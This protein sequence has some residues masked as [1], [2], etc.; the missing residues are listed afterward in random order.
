MIWQVYLSHTLV[1]WGWT[2]CKTNGNDRKIIISTHGFML[3]LEK[4]LSTHMYSQLYSGPTTLSVVLWPFRNIAHLIWFTVRHNLMTHVW[5][6]GGNTCKSHMD[7]GDL[8]QKRAIRTVSNNEYRQ[9]TN[10]QPESRTNHVY[11]NS[12]ESI[13]QFPGG[14]SA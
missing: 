7:P 3:Q 8:T 5:K 9:Q 4:L 2:P 6:Y 11:S 1:L 12:S 13:S 14:G 10:R